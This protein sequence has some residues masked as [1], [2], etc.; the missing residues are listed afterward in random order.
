MSDDNQMTI[1]DILQLSQDDIN[2][3]EVYDHEIEQNRLF[4]KSCFTQTSEFPDA[5]QAKYP[6]NVITLYS[7][8]Q[9]KFFTWGLHQPFN[10]QDNVNY[11]QFDNEETLLEHFIDYWTSNYPDVISG[12]NLFG[13][14]LPYIINR[15]S[16]LLGE[17]VAKRLSPVNSM[18]YRDDVVTVYGKSVGKWI[19]HG[20]TCLDYMDLYKKFH[21]GESPSYALNFVGEKEL[22]IGKVK[23]NATDLSTLAI[24]DWQ[25]FVDYNIQDVNILVELDKKLQYMNLVRTI[26]Y[27]G[28][29]TLARS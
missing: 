13:F 11:Y 26:A 25:T 5:Q 9:E 22:G 20:L 23:Y 2:L 6:I 18:Y 21:Q 17:D 3:L 14:D 10:T 12:W 28:L 8:L 16:S 4:T 15:I 19:V 1:S 24:T 7:T 29:T 27:K